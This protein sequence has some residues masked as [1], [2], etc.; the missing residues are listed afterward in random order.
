[1]AGIVLVQHSIEGRVLVDIK[2]RY[3]MDSVVGIVLVQH[4]I[5]EHVVPVHTKKHYRM[6]GVTGHTIL[7]L[8]I[9]I[10]VV[11]VVHMDMRTMRFRV[12]TVLSVDGIT[13]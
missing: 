13:K 2:K 5:E 11:P 6:G 1:V 7:H 4:N 3:H 8:N 10:I 12:V 9:G